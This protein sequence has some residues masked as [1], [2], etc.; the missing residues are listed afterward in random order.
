MRTVISVFT[1]FILALGAHAAEPRLSGPVTVIDGDTIEIGGARL[2]L[3][4]IDAPELGQ[5]CRIGGR[6]YD[7]G[8][9]ARTALIDLTAGAR[10]A[11]ELRASGSP[12]GDEGRPARCWA[13]G[14]DL[15]EGMVYTGW[16][17]ANPTAPP[18]YAALQQ[19]AQAAPRGLW[20]G[21]FLTPKEW[22]A[23]ARLEERTQ[24]R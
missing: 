17:I 11:C 1:V 5:G 10:V 16:A 4:G 2:R 3:A 18:R 7:C 20:K 6:S 23:G 15:S 9:V 22:R 12:A 8:M 19:G 21:R 13:D 24:D 14:Y